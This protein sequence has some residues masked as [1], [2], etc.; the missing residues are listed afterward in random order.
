M[1]KQLPAPAITKDHFVSAICKIFGVNSCNILLEIFPIASLAF[2]AYIILKCLSHAICQKFLKYFVLC[3]TMV[4]Y[5]SIAFHWASETTLFSHTGPVQEFGRSLAPRFVYVIGGLS[6]AI[7]ALYRIF[8]PSDHLK[9][10]KRITILVAIML[11]SWSPTILVLLGRQGPFVA[12]IC[13]TGAW[14]II[15]LQQKCQRES[16]LSVADPV[17]VIQWS[18]LAVCLFYLTGHW[19]TFDGLRYGAAFIGFDHFHIIRQGLLLSIDTFGVS[20]ILPILS[21]PFI[22]VVWYNSTSKDSR[23]KDVILNNITQVLLMYGLVT[24]IT[25]TM[26]IICVTIQRR[27]LMVTVASLYRTNHLGLLYFCFVVAIKHLTLQFIRQTCRFGVC[28]LQNTYLMR[29]GFS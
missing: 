3:G 29:S 17:S 6:L 25:A 24:A 12:L 23:L 13:M 19:C 14:C 18:F 10:N 22:A 8:S 4:S 7:S 5:V 2:V 27:H 1:S 15:K 9:M 16:G 28:L 11:C 20:H 21:L 26:T